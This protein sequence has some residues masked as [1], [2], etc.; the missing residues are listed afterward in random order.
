MEANGMIYY[1]HYDEDCYAC[2]VDSNWCYDA[3]C[4]TD[5]HTYSIKMKW[6]LLHQSKRLYS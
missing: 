1:L 3:Q 5:A 4:D 2:Y 6:T